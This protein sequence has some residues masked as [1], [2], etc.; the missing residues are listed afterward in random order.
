MADL[1]IPLKTKIS[2]RKNQKLKDYVYSDYT[3]GG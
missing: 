3:L 1:Q 2:T